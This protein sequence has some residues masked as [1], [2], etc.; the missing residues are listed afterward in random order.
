M[1]YALLSEATPRARKEHH[2]NYCGEKILIG[3]QYYRET[4]VYDGNMQDI[5]MHLECE[6][7]EKIEHA[8]EGEYERDPFEGGERPKKH[9]GFIL[10]NMGEQPK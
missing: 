5:P 9:L 8:G 6:R 3:E 4:S 2:C 10:S 7:A 1:S